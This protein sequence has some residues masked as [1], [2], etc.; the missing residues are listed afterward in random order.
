MRYGPCFPSSPWSPWP[1]PRQGAT[2]RALEG[3]VG[4]WCL[5]L[6]AANRRGTLGV[7][8]LA[9][10]LGAYRDEIEQHEQSDEKYNLEELTTTGKSGKT[11][12]ETDSVVQG[13]RGDPLEQT[14]HRYL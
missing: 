4:R 11:P 12:T 5:L 3:R 6:R 2:S 9:L 8:L 10:T 1:Q 13:G 7:F 14:H